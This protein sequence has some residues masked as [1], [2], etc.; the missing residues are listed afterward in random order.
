[1]TEAPKGSLKLRF[2]LDLYKNISIEGKN[3][4]DLGCNVGGF[5]RELLNRDARQV[6]A[7]D[8]GYGTLDWSLRNDS[9]VIVKERQNA[10]HA[11]FLRDLD[12]IVSDLAWTRQDKIIPVAFRY[13]SLEGCIF[14]LLKPQYEKAETPRGKKQTILED[15]EAKRVAESVIHSLDIPD[16]HTLH[17]HESPVRGGRGNKGNLEYWLVILPKKF[18]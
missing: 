12:I 7:V 8:T 10:L 5:T 4:A 3:C 1:M 13:L 18:Y 11:D 2:I 14:S 9:K 6:T 17:Y 16:T 15:D